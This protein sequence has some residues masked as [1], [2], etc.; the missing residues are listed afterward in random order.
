MNMNTIDGFIPFVPRYQMNLITRFSEAFAF[1]KKN[2]R[3]ER[4]MNR[5]KVTDFF[6]PAIS[7]NGNVTNHR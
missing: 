7:E 1:F 6:H 4:D 3:I 5:C 2:A